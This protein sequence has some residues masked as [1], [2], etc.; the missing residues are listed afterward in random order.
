MKDLN[1]TKALVK[2]V[3]ENF[4]KARNNDNYCYYVVCQ[5]VAMRYDLNLER[6]SVTDFFL[7]SQTSIFPPFE[8]VRRSRQKVQ[9]ENPHLAPCKRVRRKRAELE[10]AYREFAR[11]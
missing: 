10:K 9:E 11:S 8:S 3:L 6:I 4:E 7:S 5:T 2:F 1:S